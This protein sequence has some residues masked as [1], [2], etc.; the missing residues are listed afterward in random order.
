MKNREKNAVFSHM[1]TSMVL[2]SIKNHVPHLYCPI[3]EQQQTK[4]N[5]VNT[6]Y[7]IIEMQY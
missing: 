7:T 1:L 6:L 5:N 4:R 3:L 2:F